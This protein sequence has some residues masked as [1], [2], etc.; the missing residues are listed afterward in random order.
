MKKEKIK[1]GFTLAETLIT[2]SILGIVAA[3][4]IPS[5]VGRQIE[6]QNRTKL[7]KAM[8]TYEKVINNILIEND[9][10]TE[11]SFKA[12]AK[13]DATTNNY[14]EQVGYFKVAEMSTLPGS[15]KCR[16]KTGERIWW[17]I[18]G[19][20]DSNIENAIVIL[21]EKYKDTPRT[22][23]NGLEALAKV[24]KVDGKK[25]YVYALVGH[26]D[27]TTG[28][29]R[30][31][32]KAYE[33]TSPNKEYLEKDYA[34]LEKREMAVADAG[35]GTTERCTLKEGSETDYSC[36]GSE[37]TWKKQTIEDAS[38]TNTYFC[39]WDPEKGTCDALP[40][41]T[42]TA[43]EGDLFVSEKLTLTAADAKS[44]ENCAT[45]RDKSYCEEYGDYWNLARRKCE[46]EG[47]R[48]PTSA[49]LQAMYNADQPDEESYYWAAEANSYHAY[50][51][52]I[53][54]TDNGDVDGY[55]IVD[56]INDK[57]VCVGN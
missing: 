37:L 44:T 56:L 11:D 8:A 33:T 31:N 48:L 34:F 41:N 26:R 35:G 28:S 40:N 32:D 47:G 10:Q 5:L 23:E 45:S 15:E 57:V 6:N 30:I 21:D 27:E 52:Y 1:N 50:D 13:N 2:L 22:G 3:I 38:V 53:F 54:D 4:T 17:D 29:V 18:C 39:N 19:V 51:S 14:Q 24:E 20:N 25:V 55:G 16:F 43:S 36:T 42:S 46:A 49:E 7:K 9:L 12:W